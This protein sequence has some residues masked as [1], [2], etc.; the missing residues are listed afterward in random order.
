[1]ALLKGKAALI[2]GAASGLGEAGALTFARE[3][4]KVAI[5]DINSEKGRNVVEAIRSEGGEAIFIQTDV[6]NMQDLENMVAQTSAH[7]GKL[8]IFW[9][10]AGNAG[11]G[12]I[13]ETDEAAYD[14][15]MS[16]HLK[17]GFFGAKF[18][19]AEMKK[20]ERGAM[21]FTS[22]LAGL[23]TSRASPVYGIAKA[24]LIALTKNLTLAF[25]PYQIRVNAICP[26]AAQTALWPAF[27]NRGSTEFDPK[28]TQA[29]TQFYLD[30]TPLGRL[31]DPQDIANGALYL[32][33]DLASY[34]TGEILCVDGGL[35]V[36]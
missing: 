31:T 22:S 32:C 15:T 28:K 36:T 35:S 5:A 17:A 8:D 23:K 1:M 2:T 25:A 11:P 24:G 20:N 26:G 10:N 6:S 30:K 13:E 14:V 7:F 4:A 9:H 33:S 18:A 29:V 16:I 27:T 34:V 21:L 12:Q 3:G 19:L